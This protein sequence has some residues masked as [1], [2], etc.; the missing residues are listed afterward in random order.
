MDVHDSNNIIAERV[1]LCLTSF[2]AKFRDVNESGELQNVLTTTRNLSG[3]RVQQSPEDF[4]EQYLIEPVLHGLGFFNPTSEKYDGQKPHFVRR[5]TTFSKIEPKQPDYLL[6]NVSDRLICILEAKAAN[7]EQLSGSKREATS[8]IEGYLESDTFCK[9]L[10]ER[11]SRYLV[12]L[13]TDG[14]RWTLWWK[15]LST[16]EVFR[17]CPTVDLS[18]LIK[19]LARTD[20]VIAGEPTHS[21]PEIRKLLRE[22]FVP[23][24]AAEN[25]PEHVAD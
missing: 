22:E 1:R 15:N 6:K 13:G 11:E 12:G 20:S 5:P 10:L 8:D 14:L 2:P 4:T 18:P 3:P 23:Y 19:S 16:G 9:Y 17:E 7:R 21:N 24:F 25:L